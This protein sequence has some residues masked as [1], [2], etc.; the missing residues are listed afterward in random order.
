LSGLTEILRQRVRE[1]FEPVAV[2]KADLPQACIH[3][4]SILRFRATDRVYNSPVQP[5]TLFWH[6][7][8]TTGADARRDRP[9]QFAGV[10]TDLELD[11]IGEPVMALM[12]PQRDALPHPEACL[13]T[14]ITPQRAQREGVS[15]REF[16]AL[17][18]EQLAR[19]GTCGVGFNSI[20]FDDEFTR[21]LLYRNF[22]DPYEREWRNDNSRWDLIDVAR[23]CYALRPKGLSWPLR[24]DGTPSFRLEELCHANAIELER[25]HEALTDALATLG[26]ARAIRRAQPRLY[27]FLFGLRR[28]RRVQEFLDWQRMTPVLH[29]SARFPARRG[30]LALVAPITPIPAQPN[31]IAVFDL[32]ADPSA[33]IDLPADE[34]RERVFASRRDLPEDEQRIPLKLVHINRSPVLAPTATLEGVDLGRIA[35]DPERCQRHLEKLRTTSGLA[36]KVSAVFARVEPDE[37][38]VSDPELA[39]YDGFAGDADRALFARV[40][41]AGPRELANWSQ[42]FRDRR[43]E[44]LLFRYRARNWPESLGSGERERWQAFCRSRI[45]GRLPVAG[46]GLIEYRRLLAARRTDPATTPHQHALLDALDAWANELSLDISA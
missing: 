1:R 41:A 18:N 10:R 44:E 24:E 11:P 28:K 34:V 16:A 32:D 9:V 35:L 27:E 17:V 30:C 38:E 37:S 39:L 25:A 5:T 40:R 8:E 3:V 14:G 2:Q 45:E 46:I 26:L 19:P 42:S 12:Q 22:Y 29:V 36:N 15:E 4:A 6:D 13:I 33:L 7:Y 20:R 43:Y 21:N 23:A 31:A